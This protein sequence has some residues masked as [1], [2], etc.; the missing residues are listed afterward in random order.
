MVKNHEH[1]IDLLGWSQLMYMIYPRSHL[2]KSLFPDVEEPQLQ[3]GYPCLKPF[4]P[5]S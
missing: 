3:L 4:V 2:S 5:E 1:P